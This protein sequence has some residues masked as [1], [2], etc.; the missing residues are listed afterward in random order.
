MI[1]DLTVGEAMIQIVTIAFSL[2]VIRML[3][4]IPLISRVVLTFRIDLIRTFPGILL[5]F[6]IRCT[7]SI[8]VNIV[9]IRFLLT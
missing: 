2:T 1:H 6:W 8:P 3:Q 5:S 9:F 4:V 7:I